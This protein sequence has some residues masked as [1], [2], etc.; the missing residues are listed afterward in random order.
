MSKR[1]SLSIVG[2]IVVAA[3]LASP[4]A[5]G[6]FTEARLTERIES[7]DANPVVATEVESYERGWRRSRATLRFGLDTTYLQ[8]LQSTNQALPPAMMAALSIPVVVELA[9]GPLLTENGVGLGTAAV[10]AF[11]DP[12][13]PAGQL[14]RQLLGVPYLLEFRGRAGFGTG[15]DF[16]GE[17]P[18]FEGAF[19]GAS[20]NFSGLDFS[21]RIDG[22]DTE[23]HAEITNAALQAPDLS[24]MMESF[25]LTGDY[26]YRPNLV[27]IG[28]GRLAIDRITAANPLLGGGPLFQAN[29]L[30]VESTVTENDDAT[31]LGVQILYSAGALA[32]ADEIAIMNAAIGLNAT[33]IDADAVGR[34]YTLMQDP[35]VT[36][37]PEAMT[38][39]LTSIVDQ[40]LAGSPSVSI[41]PLRF[42][43]P[44][45]DFDARLTVSVDGSVLPPGAAMNLQNIGLLLGALDASLQATVSKPLAAELVALG[46][47]QQL[48]MT[49]SATGEPLAPEDLAAM[50]DAQAGLTLTALTAQGLL[51]DDGTSYS[52]SLEFANGTATANGQPIPLGF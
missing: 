18:P 36:A 5:I 41:D 15:F 52:I 20:Y 40:I 38:A 50:A 27:L 2:V 44:S 31:R 25:S 42:S 43:M 12:D 7:Y 51:V 4:Y 16:E 48:A 32:V 17:I 1:S 10:R 29:D 45:G 9:H 26:V 28:T 6:M 21:G 33:D 14:A 24:A 22:A 8:A 11:I 47:R 13:W 46:L 39:S 37:D 19:P 34:Y 3:L 30:A 49:G 35:A 23:I